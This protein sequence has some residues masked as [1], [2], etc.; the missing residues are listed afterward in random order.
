MSLG[1]VLL[2]AAVFVYAV[3]GPH[4]YRAPC[5]RLVGALGDGDLDGHASV[6]VVQEVLHQRARRT[7]DRHGAVRVARDVATVCT[8]HDV[9]GD[10]L[11][12]ALDLFGRGGSLGAADAVHVATAINRDLGTVISPDTDFDEPATLRRVDPLDAV[13][14][15]D[16]GERRP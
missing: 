2:D 9:T 6:L 4:P 12:L 15:L 5:Q 11:R 7:G 16:L 10:D 3:G 13:A 14:Y 8:L 1:S